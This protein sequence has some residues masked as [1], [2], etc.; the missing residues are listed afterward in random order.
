MSQGKEE[1]PLTRRSFIK[2]AGLSLTAT[3]LGELFSACSSQFVVDSQIYRSEYYRRLKENLSYLSRKLRTPLVAEECIYPLLLASRDEKG[4]ARIKQIT[5]DNPRNVDRWLEGRYPLIE[6]IT[7]TSI[8][9]VPIIFE[10]SEVGENQDV[11]YNEQTRAEENTRSRFYSFMKPFFRNDGRLAGIKITDTPREKNGTAE[12]FFNS[13]TFYVNPSLVASV[14]SG[15]PGRL[16]DYFCRPLFHE[17]VH[18]GIPLSL[19]KQVGGDRKKP[20]IMFL[21]YRLED[22]IEFVNYWLTA[23]V[24]NYDFFSDNIKDE[25]IWRNLRKSSPEFSQHGLSEIVALTL[26]I[27]APISQEGRDKLARII[28]TGK[29]YEFERF[30]AVEKAVLR[31]LAWIKYGFSAPENFSKIAPRKLRREGNVV[32]DIVG[33]S[34]V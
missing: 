6:E 18:C 30:P 5:V 26:G 12:A 13:I 29:D 32:K 8:D 10:E 17:L 23:L 16:P 20:E 9:D 7:S 19:F 25:T 14:V 3:A 34:M 1:S 24:E 27:Y 31:T 22:S 21:P 4:K 15:I 28:Q 2:L 33:L 11:S